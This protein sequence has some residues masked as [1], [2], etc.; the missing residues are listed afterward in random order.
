M[1]QSYETRLRRVV[2]YIHDNPDGDLSL[3][4]LA[5]AAALSRFH[6]HRV[7]RTM[8]G[9]TCSD[10]V[11]RIRCHRASIWLTRSDTS[12]DQIATKAG[13][14]NTQSF[15]R[16]FRSVFGQTPTEF[17]KSGQPKPTTLTLTIG[18][19]TMQ[20][21]SIRTNETLRLAAMDHRGPYYEI[22]KA[23]EELSAIFS[24]R[25]LW[26]HVHGIVALYYDDI[27][28][29][30]EAELR[31]AAGF[32]VGQNFDMPSGVQGIEVT[33]ARCAVLL[34]EGA[35]SGLPEAWDALYRNWLPQSGETLADLPPYEIYL[36]DPRDTAP[37]DLRTEICVPLVSA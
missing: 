13:Y 15:N 32:S 10:A 24:A 1:T 7:F 3:D 28:Q 23:F 17:R 16:A 4:Q 26:P 25:S 35:Y 31:S 2:Q 36:N 37:D 21:V 11:R 6:F 27:S 12:L 33:G 9:E 29:V 20:N 22:G 8:T 5:E 34:H 19:E 14:D 18:D 30:P